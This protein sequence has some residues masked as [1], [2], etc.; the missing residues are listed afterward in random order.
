MCV[1]HIL[2]MENLLFKLILTLL[3]ILYY[4][5]RTVKH[6]ESYLQNNRA[7]Y[8]FIYNTLWLNLKFLFS[9]ANNVTLKPMA[10][11]QTG[12]VLGVSKYTI[13]CVSIT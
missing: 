9:A 12:A 1:S 10:M 2:C 6:N 13:L 4:I 8:I 3:L 7:V 11:Q 5:S